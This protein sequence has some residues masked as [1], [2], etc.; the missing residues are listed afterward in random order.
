MFRWGILGTGKIAKRF[1]QAAF[2]VPDAQVV[3]VGSRE[4]QVI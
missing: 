3:A 1:M 2:Y 4:V